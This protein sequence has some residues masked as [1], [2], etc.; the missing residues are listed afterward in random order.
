MLRATH[1]NIDSGV[2]VL[3]K[4]QPLAVCDGDAKGQTEE[5]SPA[6][7]RKRSLCDDISPQSGVK[8]TKAASSMAAPVETLG[9]K[10]SEW[11]GQ[12]LYSL[13]PMIYSFENQKA[14][15]RRGKRVRDKQLL[16]R[17]P[18]VRDRL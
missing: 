12:R 13:N 11:L 18:R 10:D 7:C 3:G 14:F 16:A 6:S 15:I 17:M 8:R 2:S 9:D 1:S 5:V 4:K